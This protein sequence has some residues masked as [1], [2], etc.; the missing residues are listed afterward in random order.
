ME[1]RARHRAVLARRWRGG[2]ELP[3]TAEELDDRVCF[4]ASDL[5][6]CIETAKL[7]RVGDPDC[8][9]RVGGLGRRGP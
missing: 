4:A 8:G 1:A 3:R 5:D 7:E 2:R 9:R 6:V